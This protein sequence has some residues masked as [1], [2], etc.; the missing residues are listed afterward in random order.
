MKRKL[1]KSLRNRRAMGMT[2]MMMDCL[3]IVILAFGSAYVGASITH[4]G[5]TS[6]IDKIAGSM[7]DAIQENRKL[8]TAMQTH[9]KEDIDKSLWYIGGYTIVYKTLDF[10]NNQSSFNVLGTS[11][12]GTSIGEFN[13]PRG[14][15]IRVEIISDDNTLLTKATRL[16]QGD[17]IAKVVGYSEG[18]VD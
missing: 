4:E 12:N 2:D 7:T 11:N 8:N 6:R 5:V 18:S 14:S 3:V 16:F 13:I 1:G 9:Y 10:S 17:G 15:M